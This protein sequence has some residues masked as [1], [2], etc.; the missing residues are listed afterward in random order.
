M[1]YA[2]VDL[3]IINTSFRALFKKVNDGTRK[4]QAI[5]RLTCVMY[6]HLERCR[7][8]EKYY[9]SGRIVVTLVSVAS[10]KSPAAFP[11]NL[12]HK[13][14]TGAVALKTQEVVP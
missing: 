3:A 11:D 1:D 10:R 4:L 9:C 12:V 8:A 5:D 13:I 6:P 14:T 7:N 2:G